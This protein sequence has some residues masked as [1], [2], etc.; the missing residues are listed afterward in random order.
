MVYDRVYLLADELKNS[1]EYKEYNTAKEA[2]FSNE[3]NAAVMK[4]YKKL[5]MEGQSYI[6]A[7]NE[8]PEELAE[9][10]KKLYAVIQLSPECMLYLM[11][12]YKLHTTLNEVIGILTKSMDID[13]GIPSI[14]E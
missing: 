4:E 12:E 9:K 14:E 5:S 1:D 13:F 3:T 10:L 7:G 8:L 6:F 2:V 11:N